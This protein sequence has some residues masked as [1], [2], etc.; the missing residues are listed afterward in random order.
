MRYKTQRH[1]TSRSSIRRSRQK[2]KW[3][4][5]GICYR[6]LCLFA[7]C[8][9]HPLVLVNFFTLFHKS[10]QGRWKI[11]NPHGILFFD[12]L[13]VLWKAMEQEPGHENRKIEKASMK[14]P[15]S[16][17]CSTVSKKWK[18]CI[19]YCK[20]KDRWFKRKPSRSQTPCRQSSKVNEKLD[21]LY[22]TA[23]LRQT[24]FH[25]QNSIFSTMQASWHLKK[26]MKRKKQ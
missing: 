16:F 11:N 26:I 6:R 15:P 14:H 20:S 4:N 18:R 25:D 13:F 23:K 24:Q 12:T 19:A 5:R 7:D 2:R 9:M 17:F 1:H 10:S 21:E 3:C 22:I 8:G